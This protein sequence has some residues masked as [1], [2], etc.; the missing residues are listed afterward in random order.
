M[1]QQTLCRVRAQCTVLPDSFFAAVSWLLH[2]SRITASAPQLLPHRPCS[3]DLGALLSL[4]R[5]WLLAMAWPFK[6]EAGFRKRKIQVVG[7][8][9]N[10][11]PSILLNGVGAVMASFFEGSEL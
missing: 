1:V 8:E 2:S 7:V 5:T 10:D 3:L 4:P 11:S 6:T 9:R